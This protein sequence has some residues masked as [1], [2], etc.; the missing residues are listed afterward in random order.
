[1]AKCNY[2]IA[3]TEFRTE[4]SISQVILFTQYR[5]TT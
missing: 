5:L 4:I 3:Y 2:V 1:M